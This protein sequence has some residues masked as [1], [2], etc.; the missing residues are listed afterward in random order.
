MSRKV[1]LVV[2]ESCDS[3]YLA[4]H[5]RDILCNLHYSTKQCIGCNWVDHEDEEDWEECMR[6]GASICTECGYSEDESELVCDNCGRV[7]KDGTI[8]VICSHCDEFDCDCS[9]PS[10]LSLI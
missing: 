10:D 3:E 4:D 8:T 7:E 2:K 6:C 5:L 1:H 9:N